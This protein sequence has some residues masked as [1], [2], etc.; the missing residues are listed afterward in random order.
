MCCRVPTS[1]DEPVDAIIRLSLARAN[2]RF[3][4]EYDL[5]VSAQEWAN[6]L[7]EELFAWQ[8]AVEYVL[9]DNWCSADDHD[10]KAARKALA[11]WAAKAQGEAP[12]LLAEITELKARITTLE[13]MR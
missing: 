6:E 12:Q 5:R 4:D 13:A 11:E 10:A 3:V 7:R 2:Q 8:H 1:I 9:G